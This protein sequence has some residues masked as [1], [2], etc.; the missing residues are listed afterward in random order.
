MSSIYI[1]LCFARSNK[2]LLKT[3]EPA[4]IVVSISI[5]PNNISSV[6]FNGILISSTEAISDKLLNNVDLPVPVAPNKI[7]PLIFSFTNAN[8]NANFALSCPV[9]LENGK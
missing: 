5:P 9:I 1:I 4:L 3:L 8:I 6:I 2:L 7:T